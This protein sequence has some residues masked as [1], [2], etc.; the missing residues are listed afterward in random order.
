MNGKIPKCPY[1]NCS[2]RCCDFQQGNFIATHPRELQD[3]SAAGKSLAHLRVIDAVGEGHKVIC[4]AKDTATCD[5]GYKPLDCRS[6]PFF[7]TIDPAENAH[8]LKAGL[9]GKKCP[10]DVSQIQDHAAW[11]LDEWAAKILDN[12]SIATWLI[13]VSLVGYEPVTE[14][15]TKDIGT[16]EKGMT[17]MNGVDHESP[18]GRGTLDR[19]MNNYLRARVAS[20]DDPSLDALHRQRI[21]R[22]PGI[23]NPMYLRL[24]ANPLSDGQWAVFLGEYF[25][26]SVRGFFEWVLPGAKM[27]GG[28][29]TWDKYIGY[30][31]EEEA[32]HWRMFADLLEDCGLALPAM[33]PSSRNYLIDMLVGYTSPD[34][35]FASGYALGVEVLA[36]YEIAVLHEAM[37]RD[38]PVETERTPWFREHLEAT[39]DEHAEMSIRLVNGQI[40]TAADLRV[41]TAGFDAYC[42]D[43]NTFM[44]RL[45]QAVGAVKP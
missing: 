9:K 10:L 27:S 34:K 43:V 13:D 23:A 28:D 21:L 20:T 19:I 45:D 1:Q 3:A 5:N 6:Y 14:L 18:A 44:A 16:G 7:P 22:Q 11:V 25:P 17:D 40:E 24:V 29:A 8:N 4:T 33:G 41:V 36:G 26:G 12:P 38:F 35:R 32:S 2:F 37:K 30:I 31:V 42:R 39:E 15:V